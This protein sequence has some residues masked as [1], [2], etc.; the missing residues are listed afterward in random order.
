MGQLQRKKT[1]DHREVLE[2][3]KKTIAGA[4]DVEAGVPVR[5]GDEF[6]R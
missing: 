5:A 4:F 1:G 6:Q 2:P 3:E